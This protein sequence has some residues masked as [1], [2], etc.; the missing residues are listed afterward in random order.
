MSRGTIICLCDLT[1]IMAGPWV[2]AG[3]DAILIDPQH[4][5]ESN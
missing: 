5:E 3:Y 2:A 4:I 1:G